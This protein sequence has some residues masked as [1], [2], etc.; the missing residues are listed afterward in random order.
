VSLRPRLLRRLIAVVAGGMLA[1]VLIGCAPGER[2][3]LVEDVAVP[4]GTDVASFMPP[5]PPGTVPLPGPVPGALAQPSADDAIA[6]W[7]RSAGVPF[8]G[9]CAGT[10]PPGFLCA[11]QT[12]DPAVYF[13]GPNTTE[14]WHVVQLTSRPDGFIIERVTMAGTGS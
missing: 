8:T 11:S 13:L 7:A 12:T 5:A 2:P 1:G 14:L 3:V 9:T 6:N 10:T 4:S